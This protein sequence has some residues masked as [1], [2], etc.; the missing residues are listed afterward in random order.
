MRMHSWKFS[1]GELLPLIHYILLIDCLVAGLLNCDL[2][3]IQKKN[4]NSCPR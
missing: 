4:T 3:N 2:T 1:F